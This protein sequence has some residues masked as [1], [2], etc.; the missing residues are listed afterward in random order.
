MLCFFTICTIAAEKIASNSKTSMSKASEQVALTSQKELAEILEKIIL[1]TDNQ[2]E[3]DE[4]T[5]L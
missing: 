4:T 5:E 2:L 3:L 1:D